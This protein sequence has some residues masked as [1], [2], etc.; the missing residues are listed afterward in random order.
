MEMN[1]IFAKAYDAGIV[2]GNNAKPVPMGVYSADPITGRPIAFIDLVSEGV[3]GFAW[4]SMKANTTENKA[5]LKWAKK[6]NVMRKSCMGGFTYWVGEFNQSMQRKEAFAV[7]FAK[8]LRE[9]GMTCYT[10]SRMD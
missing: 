4:V 3:C 9:H 1:E 2:A 8:V 7:A 10:D 5:F 6:A